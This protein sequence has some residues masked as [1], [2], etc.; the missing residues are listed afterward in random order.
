MSDD[1][2]TESL[3]IL[4]KLQE[5]IVKTHAASTLAFMEFRAHLEALETVFC[6]SDSDVVNR[7]AQQVAIEQKKLQP[8]IEEL[9]R[10]TRGWLADIK[11]SRSKLSKMVH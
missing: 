10:L 9:N 11:V 4:L 7:L 6:A 8:K 5:S 3:T 1:P 2:V